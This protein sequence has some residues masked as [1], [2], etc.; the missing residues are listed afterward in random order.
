MIH[1]VYLGSNRPIEPVK[2]INWITMNYEDLKLSSIQL[3]AS[4]TIIVFS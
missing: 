1:T 4:I 2:L 3:H